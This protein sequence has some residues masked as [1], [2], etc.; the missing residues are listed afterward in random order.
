MNEKTESENADVEKEVIENSLQTKLS[1]NAKDDYRIVG[2]DN[3]AQSVMNRYHT[4]SSNIYLTNN[5]CEQKFSC[6]RFGLKPQIE[7]SNC[8][9]RLE[10]IDIEQNTSNEELK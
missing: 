4:D 6:E 2:D 10:N 7:S 3:D 9:S 5:Y 1:K 8:G